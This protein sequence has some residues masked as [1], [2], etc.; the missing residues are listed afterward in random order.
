MFS[1]F[2]KIPTTLCEVIYV[3]VIIIE[4]ECFNQAFGIF[5]EIGKMIFLVWCFLQYSLLLHYFYIVK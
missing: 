2:W 4:G 3:W 5:L 1:G